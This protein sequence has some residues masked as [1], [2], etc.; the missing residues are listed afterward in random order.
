MKRAFEQLIRGRSGAKPVL[1]VSVSSLHTAILCGIMA[2]GLPAAESAK[3][4]TKLYIILC[5]ADAHESFKLTKIK[6]TLFPDDV[7]NNLIALMSHPRRDELL[8]YADIFK[9]EAALKVMPKP[10]AKSSAQGEEYDGTI[11]TAVMVNKLLGKEMVAAISA[12]PFAHMAFV[13]TLKHGV[14]AQEAATQIRRIFYR[15]THV[16]LKVHESFR[17][18]GAVAVSAK[19]GIEVAYAAK[20]IASLKR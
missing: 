19:I 14:D 3:R 1:V 17:F 13:M 9:I 11:P 20:F 4:L 2:A 5:H 7:K 8:G 6:E 12:S 10:A 15:N 18:E 16:T